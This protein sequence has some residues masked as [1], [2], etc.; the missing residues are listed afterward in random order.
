MKF[1]S[2]MN[3]ALIRNPQYWLFLFLS[4]T[5]LF[6]LYSVVISYMDCEYYSFK[7]W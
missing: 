2:Y 7:S 4:F 3:V 6:E 5:L 1:V